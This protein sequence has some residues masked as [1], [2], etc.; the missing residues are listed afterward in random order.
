[1]IAL[2][3]SGRRCCL[4][5]TVLILREQEYYGHPLEGVL[6]VTL[7]ALSPMRDAE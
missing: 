7:A 4:Y 6:P 2:Q 1:M 3:H 5:T